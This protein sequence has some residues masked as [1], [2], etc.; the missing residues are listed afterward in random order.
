[1]SKFKV[2]DK[3]LWTAAPEDNIICMIM[4]IENG[5]ATV[6]TINCDSKFYEI[7]GKTFTEDINSIYWNNYRLLT[8]LEELL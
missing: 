4:S 3:L 1:M 7:V 6:K 8:P 5:I 2:G